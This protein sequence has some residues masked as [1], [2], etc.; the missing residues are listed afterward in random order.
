VRGPEDTIPFDPDLRRLYDYWRAIAPE[1]RLP[2]RV[3]F[4]PLDVPSLLPRISLLEVHRAP[5]RY[6]FRVAGTFLVQFYKFDPT[7]QWY[8]EAFAG[9]PIAGVLE[10]F[11][12]AAEEGVPVWRRGPAVVA[13]Q[14]EWRTV[15][16]LVLPLASDGVTV[17]MILGATVVHSLQI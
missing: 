2:G 16:S 14:S 5:L 3:H 4:D 8:D 12:I 1:G 6:R 9:R 10:R 13:P 11:A 7:G 15:E 17:D